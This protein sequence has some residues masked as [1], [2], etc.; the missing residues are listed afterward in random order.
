MNPGESFEFNGKAYM[1]TT[2]PDPKSLCRG[3]FNFHSRSP[4]D[5]EAVP[6]CCEPHVVYI[7][8]AA[9]TTKKLLNEN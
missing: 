2:P 4:V 8:I 7:D 5:C 9:E 1:A 6:D 3:C